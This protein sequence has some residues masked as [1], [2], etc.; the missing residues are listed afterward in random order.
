VFF[1]KLGGSKPFECS[2]SPLV[3]AMM[4]V[5]IEAILKLRRSGSIEAIEDSKKITTE[6]R[7]YRK[8]EKRGD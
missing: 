8:G 2:N 5:C 6:S 1:G 4:L 7:K 3:C